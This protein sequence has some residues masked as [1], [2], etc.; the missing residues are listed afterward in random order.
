M[1]AGLVV[2]AGLV[3]GFTGFGSAMILAPTLALIYGPVAAVVT[4]VMLEFMVTL[5]LLPKAAKTA[6]K[7]LYLL[8][9]LG[10]A[11]GLPAGLFI[12][13]WA[14]AHILEPAF[15]A[16][17]LVLLAIMAIGIKS[18]DTAPKGLLISGVLGGLSGGATGMPGPPIILYLLSGNTPPQQTRASLILI[19]GLIDVFMLS[20][21]SLIGLMTAT[22]ALRAFLLFP[23]MACTTWLGSLGFTRFGGAHFKKV[24]MVLVALIALSTLFF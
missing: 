23:F 22:E 11:M 7:K 15:A 13:T 1:A 9:S 14:P 16:V 4:L 19:L 18:H 10:A 17:V 2:L 12:L 6:E 20:Y 8:P 3:R 5:Q 21:M 24:A